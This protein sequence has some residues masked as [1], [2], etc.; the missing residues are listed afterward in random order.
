MY[1]S[2][3]GP[4]HQDIQL[5]IGPDKNEIRRQLQQHTQQYLE[6]GGSISAV[7]RGVSGR[8]EATGPLNLSRSQDSAP[9]EERTYIPEVIAAIERRRA[10]KRKPKPTAGKR[11]RPVRKPVLDDF[12]EPVRYRWVDE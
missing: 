7:S 6:D 4:S 2:R 11:R 1:L 9:R 10:R 12:G 8:D 3:L 5:A